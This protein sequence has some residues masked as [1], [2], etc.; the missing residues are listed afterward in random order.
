MKKIEHFKKELEYIKDPKIKEFAEKAIESLP[1]YFFEIPSSSSGRYHPQYALNKSGLIRH[2]RACVMF[3]IEC[4]R[5]EW[6]NMFTEDDK[7]LIITSLLLHDG[8]KNGTN[9]SIY[10]VKKHP[11]IASQN[12]KQNNTLNGIIS[13]EYRNTICDNILIHMGGWRFS[14]GGKEIMPMPKTRMQRLV[15]F[16]DYVCSRKMFEVNFD[17]KIEREEK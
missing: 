3:A 9:G 7:D 5:L 17:V 11:V 12:I 14:K 8:F 1:N 6:Y 13:E 2:T 16:I 10:T 4:F 15:H